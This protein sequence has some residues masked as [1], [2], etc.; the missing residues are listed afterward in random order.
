MKEVKDLLETVRHNEQSNLLLLRAK[1]HS[2][3]NDIQHLAGERK[4]DGTAEPWGNGYRGRS[5]RRGGG[6]RGLGWV[7]VVVLIAALLAGS[8]LLDAVRPEVVQF[9]RTRMGLDRGAPSAQAGAGAS[10]ITRGS[11]GAAGA[12]GAATEST[13]TAAST[14]R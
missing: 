13:G 6:G 9:L 7:Q 10:G 3:E 12:S 5:A 8:L 4:S 2:L 11:T 1:R 14:R